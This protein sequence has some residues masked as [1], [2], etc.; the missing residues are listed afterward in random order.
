MSHK[1]SALKLTCFRLLFTETSLTFNK[2]IQDVAD[3]Y[4]AGPLGG[5][6]QKAFM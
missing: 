4:G 2:P 1:I 6:K 3:G 5:R